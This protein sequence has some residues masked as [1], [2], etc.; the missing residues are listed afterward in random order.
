MFFPR[1]RS[2]DTGSDHHQSLCDETPARQSFAG[3]VTEGPGSISASM[4][5]KQFRFKPRRSWNIQDSEASCPVF[6]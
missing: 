1:K 5:I 4:I 3:T 6:I 2:L